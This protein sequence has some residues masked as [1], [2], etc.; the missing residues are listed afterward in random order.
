M[1]RKLLTVLGGVAVAGAL[2]TAPATA[3]GVVY[4]GVQQS[5][6]S[7]KAWSDCPANRSC[8]FAGLQGGRPFAHFANGDGDL[9]DSSGP[10][11][12][13]NRTKSVWNRTG[14]DWCYY[15][16]A[17]FNQLIFIVEPGFQGDLLPE[18]RDRVTSLRPCP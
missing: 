8:I 7:T 6:A 17:G 14:Q 18:H 16:A 4:Q 5:D 9:G 13:N 15:D 2:S 11:G 12:M 3:Q 10:R 1:I